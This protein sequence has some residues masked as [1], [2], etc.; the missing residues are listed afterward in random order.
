MDCQGRRRASVKKP[1]REQPLDQKIM[2]L[3]QVVDRLGCGYETLLDL[4]EQGEIP[5]FRL[6]MGRSTI[7]WRIFRADL[8]KLDSETG[9]PAKPE[10]LMGGLPLL[11]PVI[12]IQP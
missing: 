3:D 8:E 10:F 6:G 7:S 1:L 12:I 4:V 5:A 9:W 11:P 2:T